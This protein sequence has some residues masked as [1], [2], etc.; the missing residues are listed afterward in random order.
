MLLVMAWIGPWLVDLLYDA[1]YE[2]AGTMMVMIALTL[3]PA[4]ITMTYDQ[5]ALAA[6][7]SRS[8]F[9]FTA[10]RALLQTSFFL[11][12]TL[13]YGLPGGIIAMGVSML[14]AYPMLIWLAQKHQAWDPRHD[15]VFALIALL[16]GGGAAYWHLDSIM[17]LITA[18]PG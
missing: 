18:R 2:Q 1:R 8:F 5:A 9:L 3:V 7:D 13:W 16:I 17:A 11:L 10:M 12:A 4:V 14:A 15:L 6:G